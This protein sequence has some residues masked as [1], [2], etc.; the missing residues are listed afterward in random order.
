MRLSTMKALDIPEDRYAA[1]TRGELEAR[2]LDGDRAQAAAPAGGEQPAADHRA[3]RGGRLAAVSRRRGRARP[4]RGC[5]REGAGPPDGRG[6]DPARGDECH[7]RGVG[8]QEQDHQGSRREGQGRAR[9]TRPG[10]ASEETADD[11]RMV[12]AVRRRPRRH[13]PRHRPRAPGRDRR[14]Q[15]LAA[16][17]DREG[18]NERAE[19]RRGHRAAAPRRVPSGTGYGSSGFRTWT[20]RAR[21]LQ[22]LAPQHEPDDPS[23]RLDALQARADEAAQRHRCRQRRAGGTRGIHGPP[24]TRSPAEPEAERQAEI[25]N[26]IEMEL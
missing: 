11:G 7:L 22:A 16:G 14:G 21:T 15:A 23:A 20:R 13:G 24:R 26:E 8:R 17:E 18:G 1:M 10:A 5:G 6:E 3:G 4:A 12:A 9:T 25:P 19:A 2:I